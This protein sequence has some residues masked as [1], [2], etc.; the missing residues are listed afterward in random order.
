ME[1]MALLWKLQLHLKGQI[2]KSLRK[3]LE[4]DKR[5]WSFIKLMT[6][7]GLIASND[8]TL[9]E[10]KNVIRDKYEISKTFNKTKLTLSKK[11]LETN[12]IKQEPQKGL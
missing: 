6:I 3:R 4:T 5:F 10:K 9:T 8:I 2:S 12:L 11:V 7:K 1:K